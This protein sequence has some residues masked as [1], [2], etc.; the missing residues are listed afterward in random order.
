MQGLWA[1]KEM[2]EVMI[3]AE[4][5]KISGAQYLPHLD[6]LKHLGKIVRRA[7]IEVNYSQGFNPHALIFMSS[8]I[9]LGLKSY[10]EYLVIDANSSASE[11]IEKF[12]ANAPGGIVCTRAYEIPKKVNIASDITSAVYEIRGLNTFNENEVLKAKEFFVMDKRAG[13]KEV[14]EKIVSLKFVGETLVCE[15]K[16][17]NETLRP[18]YLAEKLKTLYGGEH[19]DIIKKSVKFLDGLSFIE[20]VDKKKI[21]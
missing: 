14:R 21:Q 12:N 20:Y 8:P 9:A 3:I 13:E 1:S 15:L 16:F 2:C 5:T 4:Y 10:S 6:M 18:D 11:F 7:K 19:I 17:G